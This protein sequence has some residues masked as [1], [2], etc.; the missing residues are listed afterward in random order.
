MA[1][2]SINAAWA[3]RRIT[4]VKG[5]VASAWRDNI[6]LPKD[7]IVSSILS[8]KARVVYIHPVQDAR[9]ANL[10]IGNRVA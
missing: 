3:R 2:K 8:S 6:R 4:A 9:F 1:S 5:R 7:I 10:A